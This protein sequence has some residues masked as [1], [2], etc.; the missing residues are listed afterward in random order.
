VGNGRGP[1]DGGSA[2]ITHPCCIRHRQ[3]LLVVPATRKQN[4]TPTEMTIFDAHELVKIIEEL[5]SEMAKREIRD[6]EILARM[7]ALEIKN[8]FLIRT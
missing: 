5:R 8:T 4:I 6:Q 7:K 2:Q 1:T 3:A